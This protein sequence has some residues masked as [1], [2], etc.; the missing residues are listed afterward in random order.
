MKVCLISKN[1][2]MLRNIEIVVVRRP[3]CIYWINGSITQ[4]NVWVLFMSTELL[5]SALVVMR[6]KYHRGSYFTECNITIINGEHILDT[7]QVLDIVLH[8]WML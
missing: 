2:Q 3:Y 7:R 4:Q 8:V 5:Y 6:E 1:K